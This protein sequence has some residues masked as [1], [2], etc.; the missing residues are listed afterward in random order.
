[1]PHLDPMETADSPT[2]LVA[3][4]E[5]LADLRRSGMLDDAEFAAAKARV[6]NGGHPDS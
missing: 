3:E 5:K 6:L 1:M 2:R 4:L